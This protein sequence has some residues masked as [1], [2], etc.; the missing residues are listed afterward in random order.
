MGSSK[1]EIMTPAKKTV[2]NKVLKTKGEAKAKKKPVAKAPAKKKVA[3]KVKASPKPQVTK[4]PTVEAPISPEVKQELA[5]S[6]IYT[7]GRIFVGKVI[8]AKA[9]KTVRVEW[10]RRVLIPKYERYE[11]RRTRVQAHNPAAVNAKIGDTV[12]ISE[13]RPISKMKKFVVI[14]KVEE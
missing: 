12:R 11:K 9:T 2:E 14:G 8:N 1:E 4:K 10:P 7:R 6:G 5:Q 3:A 13:C